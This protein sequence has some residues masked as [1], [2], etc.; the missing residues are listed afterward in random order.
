M[1]KFAILVFCGVLLYSQFASAAPLRVTLVHKSAD[2][3]RAMQ[4]ETEMSCSDASLQLTWA[5]VPSEAERF[6]SGRFNGELLGDQEISILN[7]LVTS[8]QKQLVGISH[9]ACGETDG[10]L[11]SIKALVVHRYDHQGGLRISDSLVEFSAA[12]IVVL[13]ALSHTPVQMS[14]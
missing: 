8:E 9:F 10:G 1:K 12:G 3:K 5:I 13:E 6:T 14:H 4:S 2:P 7:E 11:P